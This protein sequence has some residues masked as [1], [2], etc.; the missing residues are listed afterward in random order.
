MKYAVLG[1]GDSNYDHFCHMGKSI[2]KRLRELGAQPVY[3]LVCVDEATGLETPVESWKAAI[4]PIIARLYE[5]S[6]VSSSEQLAEGS[7]C[8]AMAED[9]GGLLRCPRSDDGDS[10]EKASGALSLEEMTP[11]MILPPAGILD[12]F[13]A[14]KW[15][16]ISEDTI[17]NPPADAMLPRVKAEGPPIVEI[18]AGPCQKSA[19][20]CD[21][22]ILLP[23][24][25]SVER[26]FMAEVVNARIL[27]GRS[28]DVHSSSNW[29]DFRRVIQLELSLVG[30]SIDYL[31]GDSIGICC[32]NPQYALDI[33]MTRLLQAHGVDL[34]WATPIKYKNKHSVTT[35]GE[36]LSFK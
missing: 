19:A 24:E 9:S 13:S 3:G 31:P 27:T 34:T 12:A 36:I 29:I 4:L 14:C 2:D 22:D 16:G 23:E 15:L 5:L 8:D 21:L 26:P 18:L 32:P 33:V 6:V 35:L 7:P 10:E 20:G 25:W 30:S 11:P 1:L 28:A 17:L